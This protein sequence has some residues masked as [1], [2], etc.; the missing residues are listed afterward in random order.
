VEVV[1]GVDKLEATG[2]SKPVEVGRTVRKRNF[3]SSF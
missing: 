2:G 3:A 1:I